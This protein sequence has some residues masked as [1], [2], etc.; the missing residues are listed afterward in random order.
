MDMSSGE[1]GPIV[2]N[3]PS[4]RIIV[5][6]QRK[7]VPIRVRKKIQLFKAIFLENCDTFL[8][9]LGLSD[10]FSIF[11]ECLKQNSQDR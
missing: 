9:F 2:P 5:K 8:K 1:I 6:I 10:T 11:L 4:N 3:V 7:V